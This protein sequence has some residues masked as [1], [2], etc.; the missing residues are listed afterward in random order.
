MQCISGSS[1]LDHRETL[2]REFRAEV[3]DN[4]TMEIAVIANPRP[5]FT[6]Y[7]LI[8]GNRVDLEPGTSTN[9]DVSA[10]G[11]Y[12]LTNVQHKDNGTYQVVVSNKKPRP[13]LVVNFALR[14]AGKN[15]YL[16]L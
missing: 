2:Q 16:W 11:K 7:K 9:T 10:V 6:W 13:G 3:G 12:T 1:R 4:V 8:D 15:K 14:V 5:T